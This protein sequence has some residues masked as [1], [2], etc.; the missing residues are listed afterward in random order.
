MKRKRKYKKRKNNIFKRFFG[1]IF[2]ILLF[3]II[4][5]SALYHFSPNFKIK[6]FEIIGTTTISQ[7]EIKKEAE[8]IFVSSFDLFGQ[9]IIID[10]IFLSF[11]NKTEELINKF[12][13]IENISIKKDFSKS[14]IYLE[15]KEKEPV[16]VWCD[17]N[18]CSL[19]D[20]KASF[21]REYSNEEIFPTI[22]EKEKEEYKKIEIIKAVFKLEEIIKRYNLR[23]G[24]YLLYS[25][26]FIVENI[27]G[28]NII[29][30]LNNDFEWQVEK[31]ET[32][33]KQDK[34][35]NNLSKFQYID[36]RF[37]N[38]VIVK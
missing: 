8:S 15:I 1:A 6:G 12:P 22:E 9:E 2:G 37:T 34:Y 27:N 3:F 38:Q 29:F 5:F 31:I 28:C 25:E 18:K 19:L 4:T 35:L 21:V 26:K 16:I 24:K 23:T 17:I 13:E 7:E 10:N 20:K 11:K 14:I 33:L 30:D 32:V 36:L